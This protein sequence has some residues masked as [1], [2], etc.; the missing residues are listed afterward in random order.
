[1]R[2]YNI[3][4][5]MVLGL[6]MC[7]LSLSSYA[8]SNGDVERRW[9]VNAQGNFNWQVVTKNDY[10]ASPKQGGVGYNLSL[11]YYL[12][13]SPFS[14]KAGYD[15]EEL[16]MFSDNISAR[17]RQ[18]S[19]GGRYYFL[20]PDFYLQPF[21]G[22]ET[23]FH[24]GPL[25]GNG[26]MEMHEML[27]PKEIVWSQEYDIRRPRFSFAPVAG[28]D[29]YLFSSIAMEVQYGF[30]MGT[31]THFD[32]RTE[33]PLGKNSYTTRSKGMRHA[34]SIGLKVTFPFTFTQSDGQTLWN[35]IFPED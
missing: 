25:Y 1:M 16:A 8:Q 21:I 24:F 32:V 19:L 30:R 33:R 18:L 29:V 15:S 2:I 26:R 12:P 9:A 17:L 11:E 34:F 14:L 7:I 20:K 28:L 35:S 13:N 22:A 31:G 10:T 5:R 6:L 23:Y 27:G 4:Y 3:R